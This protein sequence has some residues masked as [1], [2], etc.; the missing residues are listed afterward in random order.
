[1]GSVKLIVKHILK[2]CFKVE[3]IV[4]HFFDFY[5]KSYNLSWIFFEFS[6]FVRFCCLVS[7]SLT[8]KPERTDLFGLHWCE[9]PPVRYLHTRVHGRVEVYCFCQD[10]LNNPWFLFPV[11]SKRHYNQ[12]REIQDLIGTS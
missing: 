7:V 3:T 8:F 1:M 5:F 10:R 9:S 2:M 6:L 11:L 12:E 4:G